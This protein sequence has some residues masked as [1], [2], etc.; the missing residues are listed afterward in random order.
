MMLSMNINLHVVCNKNKST[1]LLVPFD[2][3]AFF[4]I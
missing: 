3:N 2:K 4:E 1:T